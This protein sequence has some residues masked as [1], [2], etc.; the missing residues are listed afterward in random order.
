MVLSENIFRLIF[1]LKKDIVVYIIAT[2]IY[3]K[4]DTILPL[5]RILQKEKTYLRHFY[6][7]L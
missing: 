6:T 4:S 1:R 5:E 3:I 2:S 7:L